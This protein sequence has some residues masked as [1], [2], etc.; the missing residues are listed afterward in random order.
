RTISPKSIEIL[1]RELS[2]E[3][4]G[5]KKNTL[6]VLGWAESAEAVPHLIAALRNPDLQEPAARA[7]IFCDSKAITP[8]L[9]SIE[10]ER[11]E[12]FILLT[13]QILN[14]LNT[15]ADF[16]RLIP[17]LKHRSPEVRYQA[18]RLVARSKSPGTTDLLIGGILDPYQPVHETCLDPLLARC[19]SSKTLLDEVAEKLQPKVGS[20]AGHERG[21]SIEL[22]VLA[23]GEA[24]FPLLFRALKDEDAAVRQTAVRLMGTGYHHEFLRPLIAALADE[25]ARVREL[26]ATGLA[27]YPSPE[28]TDALL[29]SVRDDV[30]WVRNATYNSLSSVA[31]ERIASVFIKQFETE[32][33]MGKSVLLSALKPF[34]IH[35]TKELLLKNLNSEDPQIRKSACESLGGFNENE[36]VFHLFTMLQNDPDWSV[37]VSTIRALTHIKPF[38]LQQALLERLKV[39]SDPLVRKEILDSI[40][41]L[42]IDY[43]PQEVY[44]F[45]LDRDLA[46]SAY[47]FLDSVKSRLGRQI[48]EASR[49][50][51]PAIRRILNRIIA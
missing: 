33:P 29:A 49:T 26:A 14:E 10:A 42:G 21:H 47:E 22:L 35:A 45:L 19:E 39:D 24:A 16:Q 38:R 40:Q 7:L 43:V 18:Y 9:E 15:V 34:R 17:F 37:R 44:G 46:D 4:L 5:L 13:L 41:K 50:Q 32:G 25:D 11:N 48:V 23:R 51:S 30:V 36:I 8:L 3:G 20:D 1:I 27:A 2:A 28:A 31:D 6:E 12:E